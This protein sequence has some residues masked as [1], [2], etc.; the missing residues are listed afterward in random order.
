MTQLDRRMNGAP[1]DTPAAGPRRS[2]TRLALLL[3]LLGLACL[4]G[5]AVAMVLLFS[6]SASAF[7]GC[8]GAP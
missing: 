2:R 1:Q 8:G 3:S 6:P 5:A 7:G 4:A